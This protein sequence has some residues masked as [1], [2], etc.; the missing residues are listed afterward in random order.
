MSLISA[1]CLSCWSCRFCRTPRVPCVTVTRRK[2]ATA[3]HEK[4]SDL[5]EPHFQT[6]PNFG[7]NDV[8]CI[9]YLS[10]ERTWNYKRSQIHP[11]IATHTRTTRFFHCPISCLKDGADGKPRP[12]AS[13]EWYHWDAQNLGF[14]EPKI[15]KICPKVFPLSSGFPKKIEINYRLVCISWRIPRKHLEAWNHQQFLA[16]QN[17]ADLLGPVQY[18]FQCT[19]TWIF[20]PCM[21]P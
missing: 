14:A 7:S 15:A 12:Y 6:P 20:W 11:T 5:W 2:G 18:G 8:E 19:K 21:A 13:A 4:S 17:S 9:F 3:K 16:V 10:E 1:A